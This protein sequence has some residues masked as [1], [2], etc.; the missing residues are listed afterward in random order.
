MVAKMEEYAEID[1]IKTRRLQIEVSDGRGW[2]TNLVP[3][4]GSFPSVAE[5]QFPNLCRTRIASGYS[6]GRNIGPSASGGPSSPCRHVMLLWGA[7]Q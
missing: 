3:S 2:N 7:I 5:F 1:L 6:S 4:M